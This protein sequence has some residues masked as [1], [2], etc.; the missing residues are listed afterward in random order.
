MSFQL[1]KVG[2]AADNNIVLKEEGISRYHAEFFLDEEGN[3]FITDMNS[4]NGTFVNGKKVNGSQQLHKSDE[5]DLADVSVEWG[6]FF[7][8]ASMLKDTKIK[9]K[10]RRADKSKSTPKKRPVVLW[11]L[12]IALAFVVSGFVINELMFSNNGNDA[13]GNASETENEEGFVIP[14]DVIY[15]YECL[16]T[17]ELT[18]V[19]DLESQLLGMTS[20]MTGVTVTVEEELESGR[21]M[22]KYSKRENK[23]ITDERLER[24]QEILDKLIPEI[25][26]PRGFTYKIYVIKDEQINAFTWG[27]MIYVT[28]GMLEFV[29]NDDELACVIGHEIAHNEQGHIAY[30]IKKYKI[31]TGLF[32]N[33]LG[34]ELVNI[35]RMFTQSFNQK[36]ETESDFYG[37]G[38]AYRAGYD[39]CKSITVWKRMSESEDDFDQLTN[40]GRSHPYSSKRANCCRNHIEENYKAKCN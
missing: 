14:E 29:E 36:K 23:F 11:A 25:Q 40:I 38:Y 5:V 34:S 35:N 39:A 2:S 15:N 6:L 10:K 30:M 28:T 18:E 26:N 19:S 22:H 32:G 16:G 31:S 37:I 9:T 8:D 12:F 21:E 20:E 33:Q 13:S 17:D 24:V 1:I 4:T 27:G 3:V 7:S